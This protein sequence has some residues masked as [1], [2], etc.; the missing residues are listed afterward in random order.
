[1]KSVVFNA[2][3]LGLSDLTDNGIVDCARN[4][5]VKSASLMISSSIANR[6]YEK[7][8]NS[9]ISVGLHL[10]VTTLSKLLN[11]KVGKALS[12]NVRL[13]EE[14]LD[15]VIEEFRRQLDL[16]VKTFRKLPDHINHHHPLYVIPGFTKKFKDW[17]CE[18]KIPTRW[19]RD[20]GL[21]DI[22]HPDYTEFQF[23]EKEN[24]TL[25]KLI[26]MVSNFPDGV[27][28]IM[29]HP[30]MKDVGMESVYIEER[31]IQVKI[32][33]DSRLKDYLS[34]KGIKITDFYQLYGV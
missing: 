24:L 29:T 32:L 26:K 19:F 22:K 2:D 1:M 11:G 23:Y 18:T 20:L 28:E 8:V 14:E 25:N 3:D 4:G 5:V 15:L 33:T 6:S 13:N 30:G 21:I 34:Y 9:G 12:G 31:P 7:A 16:Y 17:V 10:D 27:S